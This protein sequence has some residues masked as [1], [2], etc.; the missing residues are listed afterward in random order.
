MLL[1]W[2]KAHKWQILLAV[3]VVVMMVM[4][5]SNMTL[6]QMIADPRNTL[7]GVIPDFTPMTR[8]IGY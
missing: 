6:E 5:Y 4:A 2:I 7:F 8:R 1:D 3:V